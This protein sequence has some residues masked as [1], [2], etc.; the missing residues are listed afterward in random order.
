MM[1]K[2]AALILVII[3][4][5]TQWTYGFGL[6]SQASAAQID[7]DTNIISSV[8][9]AV[10]DKSGNTVTEAV[11]EQGSKVQLDY[12]WELPNGHSYKDGDTFTFKLPNEFKLFNDIGPLPLIIDGE[13]V[14]SFV[15]NEATH[16]VVMTFND[17]IETHFDVRGSIQVKTEF[18]KQTI[19]GSTEKKI[20]FPING[21][22]FTVIVNFKP[23]NTSP[24]EKRGTAAGYNAKSISWE[25]DVN[26]NL[27]SV[28][29]AQVS[30][31]IPAG[32]AAPDPA[33]I[34]VYKLDVN[35][36]GTTV[37]GALVD[38]SQYTASVTN[39]VLGVQF[40]NSPLTKAYRIEYKTDI[41]DRDKGSFTNTASF[42][43]DNQAPITA[44][45]TV[46]VKYG[47]PLKKSSTGYNAGTQTID[48]EIKYNYNE[49][50][51]SQAN[52]VLK[53]LFD[54]SHKL[55]TN[56]I[57]VYPITLDLEGNETKGAAIPASEYTV[58]PASATDK[59]GFTLSFN[60]AVT[61]AY[62]IEYKTVAKDRV[63]A[64]GTIKN[65]V[66][67][68]VYT[69][70]GSRDTRQVIIEKNVGT[71]NYI[72]K[73][74]EWSIKINGDSYTMHDVIVKDT[75]THGG[76]KFIPGLLVV[77]NGSNDV[78]AP[79][80]FT[81]VY[82]DPVVENAGFDV[83]FNGPISEPHTITYKT[84][85]NNDWLDYNWLD[86][87]KSAK[88]EN[89]GRIEWKENETS[90]D[91]LNKE[92]TATFDPHPETKNN[93]FKYGEYNAQTKEI[94][95]TI[96]VNYNSKTLANAEV[97]DNL[98][99]ADGQSLIPESVKVL[100]MK[101]APDGKPSQDTSVDASKY[102]VTEGNPLSVKFKQPIN[103]PYYIVF[104]T[105]LDKQLVETTFNNT[106]R[107]LDGAK[108]E[109]K[110]LTASLTVPRS[111]EYVE[112][113]GQQAG[114]KINWTI[115][116]NRNQSFI[117]E[118]KI[119]DDPSG[120]QI[121]VEDSFNLYKTTVAADGVITKGAKAVKGTDY[122]LSITTDDDTGN[123]QFVLSFLKDIEEAYI[124]EYQSLIAAND[125]DSVG[126]TVKFEG[127]NVKVVTKQTS[128][129]IIVGVSS[130]S[131]TGDGTRKTLTVKK[132]D[133]A[134]S[135][136]L[137][138]GATF[139]LYRLTGTDR[140]LVKKVTTGND[141]IAEFKNLWQGKY[142]LI[143]SAAPTGYLLDSKERDVTLNS[144]TTIEVKNKKPTPTATPAPSATPTPTVAPTPTPT[145][146]PTPTPTVAPTP[147]PT[148][149][150]TP[151][152]V[153][154]ATPTPTPVT[155]ATPT[156]TPVT[157]ATPTP[158]PATP[159]TPTPTATPVVPT[160]GPTA[161]PVPTSP[162]SSTFEPPAT[163]TPVPGVVVTPTPT[164][165]PGASATA[166]PAVSP[167]AS[168][169]PTVTPSTTP[170]VP[171]V[172]STPAVP[173]AT[174]PVTRETT[175]ERSTD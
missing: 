103:S 35:L 75:F 155:P 45:A 39:G 3:M 4:L 140:A 152:P 159:A 43:G 100:N 20:T 31:P 127:K 73:T 30:D 90:T 58:A 164:P 85:F 133:E 153:T 98:P 175:T 106:A 171:T 60:H 115:N 110:D 144:S 145:V 25:I 48:W 137:L 55:V 2:R 157:P 41:V 28:I 156:P 29:H 120:N 62:K 83:K 158:T 122:T 16:N 163:P 22:P 167:T 10:Y 11:Y 101:I 134:D 102:V 105:T 59:E 95:W 121:L 79:T 47:D 112:K 44:S 38:S 119:T 26:K 109:S 17:Y 148:V 161:T 13:E 80:V 166:T 71:I 125:K 37:K 67:S 149:A 111:G 132:V 63:G 107:L 126:N 61:Q 1:K 92:V 91:V 131:G 15:V 57:K 40:T 68:D 52:A 8:T 82:G 130:G 78:V 27:N 50:N 19:T 76:L 138:S 74:V 99:L 46:A 34:K 66:T 33:D 24:I 116:I 81:L 165:S 162:P 124:L 174:P 56:S 172:T 18:D 87:N 7:T 129:D 54:D 114:G 128:K 6:L 5:F 113:S 139:D 146:T 36:D 93:G 118:A 123:Q 12:Q 135:A 32:L 170:A 64:G 65:T 154:P 147:T 21:G 142:V 9:M 150:P 77:K 86:P 168:A 42:K 70:N 23:N 14:G 169:V 104:K 117:K 96:G 89:K 51:I 108:A 160:E 53:D 141:G 143:E 94:T 84:S 151:T 69:E 173:Q 136:V 97:V 88:F 49:K 72:D